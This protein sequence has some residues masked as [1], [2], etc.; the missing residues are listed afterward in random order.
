MFGDVLELYRG[1]SG[2][3][4]LFIIL[5][6][7]EILFFRLQFF[8]DSLGCQSYDVSSFAADAQF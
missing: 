5:F 6:L 1:W 3:Q 7:F 4:I 8:L 2:C